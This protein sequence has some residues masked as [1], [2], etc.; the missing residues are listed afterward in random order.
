MCYEIAYLI[1]RSLLMLIHSLLDVLSTLNGGIAAN[2]KNIAYLLM[3]LKK[4]TELQLLWSIET[5]LSVFD[6]LI[7]QESVAVV[8]VV[9][10]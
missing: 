5:I 1:I 4:V 8:V 6:Y 9:Q 2:G 7:Q 3:A 10:K